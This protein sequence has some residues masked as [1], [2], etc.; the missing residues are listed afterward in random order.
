MTVTASQVKEL[1]ET[2]GAG[3]MDCKAAL[4]EAKGDMEKAVDILRKRGSATLQKKAGRVA[5]EG[6][7][8]AYIHAGGKLGVILEVNCETDFVARNKDFKNFVHDLAMHIAAANP[9]WISRDEISPEVI[10]KERDIYK[11]QALNEGKPEKV[12]DKIVEGKLEKF[13][14]RTCLL[15]QPFVKN[16]EITIKNYLGELVGKIGENIVIRRFDRY[17]LGEE[18]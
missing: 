8:D 4:T 6:I 17:L 3:M 12:I 5:N 1:R 2:T 11:E 7:I 10:T 14:E 15:D 18:E 13:Y 9:L 16:Q